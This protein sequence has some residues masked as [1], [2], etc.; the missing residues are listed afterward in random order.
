MILWGSGWCERVVGL[1]F[2]LSSFSSCCFTLRLLLLFRGAS[3]DQRCTHNQPHCRLFF[4]TQG[5][6][7]FFWT[8]S[9]SRAVCTRT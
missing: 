2:L 8:F 1:L 7:N 3:T 9:T 4:S 5:G 6:S